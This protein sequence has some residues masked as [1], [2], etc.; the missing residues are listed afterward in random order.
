LRCAALAAAVQPAVRG[1]L[2]RR[3]VRWKRTTEWV[4]IKLQRVFRVYRAR[5]LFAAALAQCF[6]DDV[7]HPAVRLYSKGCTV[8]FLR[9]N[10][11]RAH[12]S[13]FDSFGCTVASQMAP[14]TR[15]Q[16]C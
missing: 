3:F 14:S 10:N 12:E 11:N 6:F 4:A 8:I 15:T 16:T 2:A 9:D 1:F 13:N 5:R 7:V